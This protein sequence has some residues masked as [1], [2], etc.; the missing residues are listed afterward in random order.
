MNSTIRRQTPE[1]QA[2][3]AGLGLRKGAARER[4]AGS[5]KPCDR[6]DQL[7]AG[8]LVARSITQ[9]ISRLVEFRGLAQRRGSEEIDDG[10][11][12]PRKGPHGCRDLNCRRGRRHRAIANRRHDDRRLVARRIVIAIGRLSRHWQCECQPE[13][14]QV[15]M[16]RVDRHQPMAIVRARMPVW[17]AMWMRMPVIVGRIVRRTPCAGVPVRALAAGV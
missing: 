12:G 9:K 2:T 5:K 15:K 1:S 11:N 10:R 14:C 17:I 4:G 3:A 8:A 13:P 16:A 7:H 6:S